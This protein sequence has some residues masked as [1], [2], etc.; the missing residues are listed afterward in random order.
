ML[1]ARIGGTLGLAETEIGDPGASWRVVFSA[2]RHG[3]RDPLPSGP[4]LAE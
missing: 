2:N 4:E 3:R 1:F